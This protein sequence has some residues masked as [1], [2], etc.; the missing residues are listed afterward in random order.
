MKIMIAGALSA[1]LFLACT[2]Q[3]TQADPAPARYGNAEPS[4]QASFGTET[5]TAETGRDPAGKIEVTVIVEALGKEGL[6]QVQPGEIMCSH[7]QLLL[8]VEASRE[9]FV[10][11]LYGKRL[12]GRDDIQVLFPTD[13]DVRLRP[14]GFQRVPPVGQWL[15]L[16]EVVGRESLFVAVS[17]NPIGQDA[18]KTK[19]SEALGQPA[20][21]P[22][23]PKRVCRPRPDSRPPS[24]T[25]AS[26]CGANDSQCRAQCSPIASVELPIAYTPSLEEAHT[27]TNYTKFKGIAR[28]YEKQLATQVGDMQLI[29]FPLLHK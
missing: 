29:H 5:R 12:P 3:N 11:V 13:A 27:S 23:N 17:D 18:L 10:Y 9:A 22:P 7:E 25:C 21:R 14:G 19:V 8:R 1:A 2:H 4:A 16:D 28:V 26:K 20:M 6:R 15:K 24:A